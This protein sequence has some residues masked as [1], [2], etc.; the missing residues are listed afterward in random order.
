[1]GIALLT[2]W[3]A[4][5]GAER[6]SF[7]DWQGLHF[8]SA[9][10]PTAAPSADPDGDGRINREEY[11]RGT[12]PLAMN[13]SSGLT[14]DLSTDGSATVN[15]TDSP[16]AVGRVLYSTN[17]ADWLLWNVSGNDGLPRADEMRSLQGEVH[18]DAAFFK[19]LLEER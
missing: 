10:E 17:L 8:G 4:A 14:V 5:F 12:S 7:E 18:A 15:F 3:I 19:L 1:A 16:N 13:A 11:L 2:E 6:M 9:S